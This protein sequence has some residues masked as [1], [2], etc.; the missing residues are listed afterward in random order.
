MVHPVHSKNIAAFLWSDVLVCLVEVALTST[1]HSWFIG[2]ITRLLPNQ[3]C[4]IWVNNSLRTICPQT[5]PTTAT[6]NAPHTRED[7]GHDGS[8]KAREEA[9]L[10]H[11]CYFSPTVFMWH[12]KYRYNT[13]CVYMDM[14][15]VMFNINEHRKEQ[16]CCFINS[17]QV[18]T[19]QQHIPVSY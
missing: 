17:C 11:L 6:I 3:H 15:C 10:C 18:L 1:V 8:W 19:S 2:T 14:Y 5:K 16:R 9:I 13:I 4:K 12:T 7:I